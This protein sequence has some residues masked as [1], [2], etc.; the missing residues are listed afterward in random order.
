MS[1]SAAG[2][3]SNNALA[4]ILKNIDE[5]AMQPCFIQQQLFKKE[6]HASE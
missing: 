6:V 1:H 4:V 5:A 3:M 2:D